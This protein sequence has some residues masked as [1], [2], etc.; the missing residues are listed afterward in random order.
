MK[1]GII[2]KYYNQ[3]KIAYQNKIE[4]CTGR[5]DLWDEMKVV[6]KQT[7]KS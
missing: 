4:E 5:I 7:H 3:S 6:S 2:S 1:K